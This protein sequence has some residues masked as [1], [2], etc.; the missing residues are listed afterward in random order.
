MTTGMVKA[1]IIEADRSQLCWDLVD[2]DGW[3]PA[4]HLARTVW[5]FT[6]RLDLSPLYAAVKSV[7]GEAGRPAS[8]PRVLLALWL[9]AVAK[10]TGSARELDRLCRQDLAFRWLAGGVPLNYH[11]LADFRVGQAGFLDKLLTESLTAL[12]AAGVLSLEE[13]I[14]DG[15][16]IRAPASRKSYLQAGRLEEVEKAA[17]ARVEG[18]KA[19]VEADPAASSR[20][21]RAAQERAARERLE[22]VAAA[23]RALEK[24]QAERK[25]RKKTH[26][27][28]ES[29]KKEPAASTTDPEA[30]RMRFA[31]GAV[32]AGYNAQLA[33]TSE[34]GFIVAI[35][36]TDRRNDAGFARPMAEAAGARL[37]K[38]PSRLL[39]DTNYATADDI[40]ALGGRAENPIAVYAPPQPMRE[41]AKPASLA[42]RKAKLAKEPPAVKEWRQRMETPEAAEK[43]KK[44]KRIELVNAQTKNRGFGR[45][46]VRGLIKAKAIA[47]WHALAHNLMTALRL[48]AVTQN[49]VAVA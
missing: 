32:R 9:Y 10:G 33:V 19:E 38:T 20:R 31:D 8:D 42:R 13:I 28:D 30:R 26:S 48:N 40:E 25:A 35:D 23:R 44:R 17:K 24:L 3:L 43:M 2:L 49:G 47:L 39:A 5:A 16:K 14:V 7:E 36:I 41:D 27:K 46:T 12:M 4:D 21:S 6:G 15:T 29:E 18:L 37:G 11:T 1:R 34:H 45:L 22:K